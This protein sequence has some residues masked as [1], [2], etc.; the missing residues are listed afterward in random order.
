MEARRLIEHETRTFF[1]RATGVPG[2]DD[3]VVPGTPVDDV[4]C[5]FSI[6]KVC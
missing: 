6:V 4:V 3:P 2:I 1:I 5:P